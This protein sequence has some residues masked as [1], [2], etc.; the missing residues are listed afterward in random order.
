MS[1]AGSI[2]GNALSQVEFYFSDS[3]APRDKFLMEQIQA[4]PEVRGKTG[5]AKVLIT[6]PRA[7]VK[8]EQN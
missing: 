4:D 5:F 6:A 1:I 3:N 7:A 2:T 8:F